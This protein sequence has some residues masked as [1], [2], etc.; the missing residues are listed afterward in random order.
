MTDHFIMMFILALFG[1]P[2]SFWDCCD[3]EHH[4]SRAQW[5]KTPWPGV[6][7]LGSKRERKGL[8]SHRTLQGIMSSTDLILP[9]TGCTTSQWSHPGL[10]P[11]PHWSLGTIYGPK[12]SNVLLYSAGPCFRKRRYHLQVNRR[13][14]VTHIPCL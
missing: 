7:W 5:S 14:K 1:R 3:K 12:Y 9:P 10:K 8:G 2:C 11:L 6:S 4:R 13:E